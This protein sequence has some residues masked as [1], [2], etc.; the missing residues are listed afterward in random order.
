MVH[1]SCNMCTRVL[2]DMYILI[3]QASGVHIRQ[4][5]RAHVTTIKCNFLHTCKTLCAYVQYVYVL[6][7]GIVIFWIL[8]RCIGIIATG[9]ENQAST[10][11]QLHDLQTITHVNKLFA[12]HYCMLQHYSDHWGTHRNDYVVLNSEFGCV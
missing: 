11:I 3:P 1:N 12:R 2:P 8:F 9:F 7:A 6:A 4:N 5:T 10:H